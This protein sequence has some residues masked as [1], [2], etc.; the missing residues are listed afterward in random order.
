MSDPYVPQGGGESPASAASPV[1]PPP[2]PE[3]LPPG[4]EN[5]TP[6]PEGLPP[7]REDLLGLRIAAALIDLAV[8][9]GLLVILSAA[10]G[11]TSF[12]GGGFNVSLSGAWAGVFLAIAL[13]YYFTL[14][15]AIGQTLGK[16]LLGLRVLGAGETR[17]S[18]RAVAS[19]T[20][21]RVVD[22]LP[23]LY[24]AGFITMLATGTRRRRIGDLAAR[25]A[26]ARALPVR[27]RW[28]A[29]VPLA[30]VVLAAAGLSVYR[31]S[32][33]GGT[34]RGHGVSFSYP[35]NWSDETAQENT[36]GSVGNPLWTAAFGPGTQHDLIVV[37]AYRGDFP[38]TAQNVDDLMLVISAKVTQA[39][40][41]IHG[42]D[43]K[44][45]VD[46]M[47]G[48]R[49][50]ATGTAQGA[51]F[52]SMLVFAFNGATEYFVNCQY[53]P[54]KAAEV[55]SAC[56]QVVGS[57]QVGKAASAQD[58][59]QAPQAQANTQAEQQAQSDL[60]TL[61]HD[62]Q[63]TSDLS[64]LT[65]D[66]HQVDADLAA[67]TSDAALGPGCDTASITKIDA[68]T[69]KIDASTFSLDLDTLTG[70]IGT[71]TQDIA[72]MKNDMANLTT[73]G[74]R[75]TPGAAAAIAAA[76]Q[77]I[78]QAAAEANGEIDHVNADVT[79][80]YSVANSIAAGSCSRNG[81]GHPPAPIR[82]ISGK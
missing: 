39:G 60:A 52:E 15:A 34:Y 32:S 25:T 50:H 17:P 58:N 49:I 28:L 29:L 11:Q 5:L 27:H 9:A 26:V 75:E 55:K 68:S 69:I 38:V 21:L 74:L 18:V 3:N 41:T 31:A 53:T 54:A 42:T 7:G 14:E 44:I 33:A 4:S 71:A 20:L 63:F 6:G 51:R 77:A 47:P 62:G 40:A 78:K 8:L 37:E 12:S 23:L 35:A 65:S 2:G 19:R 30:V 24:L 61:Q 72:T 56:D 59:Q 76:G 70:D 81:P 79:R 10:V 46:G 48:F 45:T 16:R 57:F 64:S 67:T 82:H 13:L 73:S 80:A 43:Q 36:S 66:A 1:L 22:W